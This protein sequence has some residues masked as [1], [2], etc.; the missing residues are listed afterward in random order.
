M[1]LAPGPER[2]LVLDLAGLE[3]LRENRIR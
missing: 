2:E 3:L 1:A